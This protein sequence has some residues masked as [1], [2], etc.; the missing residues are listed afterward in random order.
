MKMARFE[1]RNLWKKKRA[2]EEKAKKKE[3]ID[4]KNHI[5]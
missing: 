3:K 1:N 2:K 4:R 5:F